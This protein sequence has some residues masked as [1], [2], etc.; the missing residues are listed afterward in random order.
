MNDS[1]RLPVVPCLCGLV[2]MVW[3][4]TATPWVGACRPTPLWTV[5]STVTPTAPVPATGVAVDID[6]DART[7]IRQ[8]YVP[9]SRLVEFMQGRPAYLPLSAEKFREI[10]AG[11]ESRMRSVCRGEPVRHWLTTGPGGSLQGQSLVRLRATESQGGALA[12]LPLGPVWVEFDD[13][14]VPAEYFNLVPQLSASRGNSRESGRELAGLLTS[15][16]PPSVTWQDVPVA[17]SVNEQGSFGLP[18]SQA[19]EW[20]LVRYNLALATQAD[21]SGRRQIRLPNRPTTLTTVQTSGS[22][23][24]AFF[25]NGSSVALQSA[26]T[27]T[28][29]ADAENRYS[30]RQYFCDGPEIIGQFVEFDSPPRKTV[31][32]GRYSERSTLTIER[33]S[34]RFEGVVD[35]EFLQA[36][37]GELVLELPARLQVTR[38]EV[39]GVPQTCEV[40]HVDRDVRQWVLPWQT[41][42]TRHEIRIAGVL[43]EEASERI[44]IPRLR[45]P[46]HTW[47]SGAVQVGISAPLSLVDYELIDGRVLRSQA[48]GRVQDLSFQWGGPDSVI[49]LLLETPRS[50]MSP[51]VGSGSDFT[52]LTAEPEKLEADQFLFLDDRFRDSNVITWEVA[53]G[54][55]VEQVA[56]FD[57]VILEDGADQ[58]LPESGLTPLNWSLLWE[59]DRP[60]ISVVLPAESRENRLGLRI[61]AVQPVSHW[62][63]EVEGRIVRESDSGHSPKKPCLVQVVSAAGIRPSPT[64]VRDWSGM[65]AEEARQKLP[66]LRGLIGA[67]ILR[68]SQGAARLMLENAAGQSGGYDVLAHTVNRLL[69]NGVV[70]QGHRFMVQPNGPV[71]EVQLS[72]GGDTTAARRWQALSRTGQPL[73]YEVGPG[74]GGLGWSLRFPRPVNDSFFIVVQQEWIAAKRGRVPL[75]EFPRARQFQGVVDS[76]FVGLQTLLIRGASPLPSP[77]ADLRQFREASREWWGQ[78]QARITPS[79]RANATVNSDSATNLGTAAIPSGTGIP[80]TAANPNA[81]A[82]S[83][84]AVGSGTSGNQ[85]TAASLSATAGPSSMATTDRMVAAVPGAQI[86]TALPTD[87][88]STWYQHAQSVHYE[89]LPRLEWASPTVLV[90]RQIDTWRSSGWQTDLRLEVHC[91]ADTTLPVDLPPGSTCSRL[92]INHSVAE[93]VHSR[94][95]MRLEFV[96][97]G[98][99]TAQL[100]W[101]TP[102][103][104]TWAAWSGWETLPTSHPL[105][106]SSVAA[107]RELRLPPGRLPGSNPSM[108]DIGSESLGRRVLSPLVWPRPQGSTWLAGTPFG[109]RLVDRE[110]NG[111]QC[112]QWTTAGSYAGDLSELQALSATSPNA[113]PVATNADNGI[114]VARDSNVRDNRDGDSEIGIGK[115]SLANSGLSLPTSPQGVFSPLKA[116]LSHWAAL[117]LSCGLGLVLNG[118]EFGARPAHRRGLSVAIIGGLAL[119]L[120]LPWPWHELIATVW[121]GLLLGDAWRR[122]CDWTRESPSARIDRSNSDVSGRSASQRR[123]LTPTGAAWLLGIGC[124]GSQILAAPGW[125]ESSHAANARHPVG[126]QAQTNSPAQAA[127]RPASASPF[128]MQDGAA[129]TDNQP[130]P[131]VVIPVDADQRP[132]GPVVYVPPALYQ[133]LNQSPL[134]DRGTFDLERRG[135]QHTLE[136]D[137]QLRRFSRLTSLYTC[138][139]ARAK[140][141]LLPSPVGPEHA[142]R[143]VRLNGVPV[144]FQRLTDGISVQMDVGTNLLSITYDLQ[145]TQSRLQLDQHGLIDSYVVLSGVPNGWQSIVIDS[146][147]PQTRFSS[148]IQRRFRTD[149]FRGT[150]IEVMPEVESW[151]NPTIETWLTFDPMQVRCETRVRLGRATGVRN[152][153]WFQVDPRMS[154]PTGY[155]V[156]SATWAVQRGSEEERPAEAMAGPVYRLQWTDNHNPEEIIRIPWDYQGQSFGRLIPPSWR[157]LDQELPRFRRLLVVRVDSSLVY[158]TLELADSYFR[159]GNELELM[160][161]GLALSNRPTDAS[162]NALPGNSRPEVPIS[163]PIPGLEPRPGDDPVRSRQPLGTLAGTDVVGNRPNG[164]VPRVSAGDSSGQDPN[165]A[166]DPAAQLGSTASNLFV[167]EQLSEPTANSRTAVGRL[168]LQPAQVVGN[169]N[170]ELVLAAD[171]A[172]LS[173]RGEL[174]ITHGELSQWVFQLPPGGKLQRL[175]LLS[176][177][178]NEV[179]WIGAR[180]GPQSDGRAAFLRTPLQGTIRVEMDVELPLPSDDSIPLPWVQVPAFPE[181]SHNVQ[182]QDPEN[183]WLWGIEAE[184]LAGVSDSSTATGLPNTTTVRLT[185]SSERLRMLRLYRNR[186]STDRTEASVAVENA[187]PLNTADVARESQAA[188]GTPGFLGDSA[189]PLANAGDDRLSATES[190]QP[191]VVAG[192][193]VLATQQRDRQI[194]GSWA[195]SASTPGLDRSHLDAG[196]PAQAIADSAANATNADT[197]SASDTI[198]GWQ[199]LVIRNRGLDQLTLVVPS[200][201][202]IRRAWLNGLPVMAT[203]HDAGQEQAETGDAIDA[204]GL[205]NASTNNAPAPATI[206]PSRPSEFR[207]ANLAIDPL[208]EFSLLTL[209]L[210][211]SLLPEQPELKWVSLGKPIAILCEADSPAGWPAA[212]R[213][214]SDPTV[215]AKTELVNADDWFSRNISPEAG[216][217]WGVALPPGHSLATILQRP[218]PELPTNEESIGSALSQVGGLPPVQTEIPRTFSLTRWMSGIALLGLSLCLAV[219]G[220]KGLAS[221]VRWRNRPET[222]PFGGDFLW[223]GLSSAVW[224]M[225]GSW[226]L[227]TLFA[228]IGLGF[229]LQRAAQLG[230]LRRFA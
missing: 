165:Q 117:L 60:R 199:Q 17:L 188:S 134:V 22:A 3:L 186:D 176:A 213:V 96:G 123:L 2:V 208:Q 124:W 23:P 174:E 219:F 161:P 131:M 200:G 71:D 49:T 40:R 217:A 115:S 92:L 12:S 163:N 158:R 133:Q 172:V 156:E 222:S 93:S 140:S 189:G 132:V 210:V 62:P 157:I 21:A 162:I 170:Q 112:W 56:A 9:E 153:L 113:A 95:N 69:P 129:S 225:G 181:V 16:F 84:D 110:P 184:G 216:P 86:D 168:S 147:H 31:I 202:V 90:A 30:Q 72:A 187:P 64:D 151:S 183:A 166:A 33:T 66:E 32:P 195:S 43:S 57:P 103:P 127:S 135:A 229:L 80:N 14:S 104:W 160:T 54:W 7:T 221:V 136:Y 73:E 67:G 146:R 89:C 177:Q 230:F 203:A 212:L 20:M 48:L 38:S 209:E 79:P 220:T 121:L 120:L 74:E 143:Q 178:Q 101:T 51:A 5:Q 19:S 204:S 125:G 185:E 145:L 75:Y 55:Q 206:A 159:R 11:N 155:Q 97:P 45:L 207:K 50:A 46:G 141:Y 228:A 68:Q 47:M 227:A 24:A 100:T 4:A 102:H 148:P 77:A 1:C 118:R 70:E 196:A 27:A 142:I 214:E 224:L 78:H 87:Y 10:L 138:K 130:Y 190:L 94:S 8:V 211:G 106:M 36:Y 126:T 226:P 82:N 173:V 26:V 193:F 41:W 99:H 180:R 167:Y 59:Q 137:P 122:L 81:T 25:L 34:Q 105:L 53:E 6:E 111:Y 37:S 152:E 58:P 91:D 109:W 179:A 35:L 85:G 128:G 215:V 61:R 18:L 198:A 192:R 116:Q 139:A 164:N 76:S 154:L 98:R 39:N 197:T 108:S 119:S 42:A 65:T 205:P 150:R 28:E 169:L 29:M 83:T 223:F 52:R 182:L 13:W 144:L 218:W 44:V 15:S 149:R 63:L 171:A 191:E 175:A 88:L 114:G 201:W 107:H 194:S